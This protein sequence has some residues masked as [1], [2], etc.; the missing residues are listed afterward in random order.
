V[1]GSRKAKEDQVA[2]DHKKT[3]VFAVRIASQVVVVAKL[4]EGG[5]NKSCATKKKK[6]RV[7]EGYSP[8]RDFPSQ[9]LFPG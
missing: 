9:P 2:R 6:S 8:I 5:D 1:T 7:Q 4:G 3:G